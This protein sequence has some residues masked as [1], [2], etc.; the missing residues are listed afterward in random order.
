MDG[1]I[2][3]WKEL[4]FP[5]EKIKMPIRAFFYS[6]AKRFY[7]LGALVPQYSNSQ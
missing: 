5:I 3:E 7:F 4:D 6:S 2:R 1:G